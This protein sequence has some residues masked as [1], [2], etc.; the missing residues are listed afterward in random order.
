MV[1]S[2]RNRIFDRPSRGNEQ[3]N[4]FS[5]TF[6]EDTLGTQTINSPIN[7]SQDRLFLYIEEQAQLI[8]QTTHF[9]SRFHLSRGCGAGFLA[10]LAKY[11]IR[12]ASTKTLYVGRQRLAHDVI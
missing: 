3:K 10:V 6:R 4:S 12:Q 1:T 11:D 9:F 2:Q 5:P 8:H 7:R